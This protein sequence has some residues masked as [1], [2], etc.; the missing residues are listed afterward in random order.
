MGLACIGPIKKMLHGEAHDPDEPTG[1]KWAE[2]P[3]IAPS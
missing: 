2:A 3:A 1:R